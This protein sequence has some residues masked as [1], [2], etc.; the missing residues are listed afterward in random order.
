MILYRLFLILDALLMLLPRGLRKGIF[1]ALASLAHLLAGKRNRIIRQNLSFA[2]HET[3]ST[4]Q[5]RKIERYCYRNLALNL[6]QVMENR[7]NSAEDLRSQVTFENHETVDAILAQGGGIIFVSAHYGNWELGG[8]ALSSLITPV[9]SIYKGFSRSE[10]DPYLL[11]ARTAHRMELAEKNG[12]L[13]H[14]AKALKN[15]HSILLMIDQAS[16]ERYGV[17]VDFFGHK[18]YHSSTA[19]Q[20]SAKFNVP[21]VGVYISSEDEKHY[22]IRFE[23]PIEVREGDEI[24]VTEA[25]QRQ[26]EGVEKVIRENPK[27]WFWCHKRWKGEFPA[28]YR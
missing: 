16:N 14:I 7:R 3:M 22:T 9:A 11:E 10:F 20:L 6:L 1:T 13:K 28:I 21:I 18:T 2:F 25:T 24:S 15:G 12:A 17:S 27:L 5:M 23:E 8:A 4:A 19:A 26:V